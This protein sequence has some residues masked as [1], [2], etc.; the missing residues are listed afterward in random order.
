MES[1]SE[2]GYENN[3][4]KEG[5]ETQETSISTHLTTPNKKRKE[6]FLVIFSL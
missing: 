4:D 1:D 5:G 3:E 6:F 2:P